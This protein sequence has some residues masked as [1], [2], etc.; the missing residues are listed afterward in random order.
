VKKTSPHKQKSKKVHN[1]FFLFSFFSFLTLSITQ[2]TM[3]HYFSPPLHRHSFLSPHPLPSLSPPTQMQGPRRSGDSAPSGPAQLGA[4]R[5]SRF[6]RPRD[7]MSRPTCAC[8]P[9]SMASTDGSGSSAI[10]VRA[11]DFVPPRLLGPRAAA[12]LWPAYELSAEGKRGSRLSEQT[13]SQ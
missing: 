11:S 3:T 4:W 8:A 1:T 6:P 12:L 2:P 13:R 10:H 7:L 5:P 9:P